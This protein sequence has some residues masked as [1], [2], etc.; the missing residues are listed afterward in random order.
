MGNFILPA[1][2]RHVRPLAPRAP[3]CSTPNKIPTKIHYGSDQR[4]QITV[5][6]LKSRQFTLK[7]WCLITSNYP[8]VLCTHLLL[9]LPSSTCFSSGSLIH[10]CYFVFQKSGI[11]CLM[12][13]C[14]HRV[15]SICCKGHL[16]RTTIYWTT[17]TMVIFLLQQEE[18]RGKHSKGTQFPHAALRQWPLKC[19][20]AA[21]PALL[22]W[23]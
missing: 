23:R 8:A 5:R 17:R 9:T 4:W 10:T 14:V 19:G 2:H 15:Q 1:S 18:A 11:T 20:G 21:S 3:L 6:R 16:F 13:L 22:V 12:C 7:Y